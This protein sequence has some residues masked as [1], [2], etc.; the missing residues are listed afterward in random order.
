MRMRHFVI[1]DL[2][3]SA[4]FFR[5]LISD[6]IIENKLL[7]IKCVFSLQILPEKYLI[8]RRNERDVIKNV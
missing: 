8:L 7:N 3:R 6:T 5:Y 2:P 4:V 1:C